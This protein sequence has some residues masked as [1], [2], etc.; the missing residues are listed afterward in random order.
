MGRICRHF[1]EA[2]GERSQIA[3]L[4]T[5]EDSHPNRPAQLHRS[6]QPDGAATSGAPAATRTSLQA[7]QA[8]AW[9]DHHPPTPGPATKP[10]LNPTRDTS[11]L[12]NGDSCTQAGP[13]ALGERDEGQE[14]CPALLLSGYL[15]EVPESW[16]SWRFMASPHPSM[17][18]T[19]SLSTYF[20]IALSSSQ[21]KVTC[22]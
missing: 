2:G 17:E 19:P 9:R 15:E 14:G 11:S 10:S 4:N 22:K 8:F 13:T 16:G 1:P 20:E 12:L 18:C 6:Q 21:L 7:P 5:V 3:D